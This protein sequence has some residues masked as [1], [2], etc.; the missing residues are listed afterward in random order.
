MFGSF[1]ITPRH[2]WA[3]LPAL[4]RLL[5]I[6]Y[7]TTTLFIL[8]SKALSILNDHGEQYR[9]QCLHTE[10]VICSLHYF[11]LKTSDVGQKTRLPRRRRTLGYHHQVWRQTSLRAQDHTCE[12]LTVV[13]ESPAG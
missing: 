4:L 8:K 13:R 3:V 2:P 12:R 1:T 10:E 7:T 11:H 9:H 6:T 5:S